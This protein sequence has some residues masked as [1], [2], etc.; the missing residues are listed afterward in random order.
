MPKLNT[1]EANELAMHFLALA[2]SIGDYRFRNW[3]RLSR[4]ENHKLGN[5]QWSVLNFGEDMLALSTV[6]VMDDIENSLAAI[7]DLTKKVEQTLSGLGKIQKIIN[8]AAAIV[9]MGGAIIAKD[10]SAIEKAIENLA[11]ELS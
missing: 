8:C 9:S 11:K 7:G 1:A 3:K 4:K 2:Q 5:F 6:L 10:P